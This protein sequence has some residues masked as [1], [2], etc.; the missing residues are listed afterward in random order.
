MQGVLELGNKDS[1][2][3]PGD[4]SFVLSRRTQALQCKKDPRQCT[5]SPI[6]QFEGDDDN[7]TDLVVKLTVEVDGQW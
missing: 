1:G 4:T 3:V 5:G 2:D 6:A 7:S